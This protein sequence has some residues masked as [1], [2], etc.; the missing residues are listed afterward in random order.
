MVLSVQTQFD[1]KLY[2]HAKFSVAQWA[3]VLIMLATFSMY[4]LMPFPYQLCPN[5]LVH[6]L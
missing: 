2:L 6:V 1:L 3:L 5:I 4:Q